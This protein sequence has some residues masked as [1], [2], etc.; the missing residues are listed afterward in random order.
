MFSTRT[1]IACL[2]LFAVFHTASSWSLS[3]TWEGN[4][5]FNNFWFWDQSVDGTDPTHG[6]VYY[7]NQQEAWDWGLVKVNSNNSVYIGCDCWS[8]SSG[9]GRGS[10]RIQSYGSWDYGLFIADMAHM[11]QGCGTWPAWWLVGPSWPNGGEIDIIEGV[12][13]QVQ[14]QSTLHTSAGCTMPA[15]NNSFTG[16][17]DSL[18]CD[19]YDNSNSGCGITSHSTTSYGSGFNDNNGGVYAMQ[20]VDSSISMWY[21]PRNNIPS[22]IINNQANPNNWGL[23]YANFPLGSNCD[24]SHF[25]KM[26]MIINLTFCGDW[27]GSVFGSE[28]GQY[29]SNCNS[30]VQ[31]NP[32]AFCDAYWEINRIQIYQ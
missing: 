7:A 11:P 24:P 23:P 8:I 26:S 1:A 9:T 27:A 4:N 20:W 13:N 3:A 2:F 29:G 32:S 21:F 31:N 17:A 16:Y 19:A 6:Y 5:F 28:C 15:G 25:S 30:Y 10:V 14:D 18:D 22:D 12:N